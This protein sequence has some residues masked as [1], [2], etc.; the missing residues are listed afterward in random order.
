MVLMFCGCDI[1]S[2]TVSIVRLCV[3]AAMNIVMFLG[4]QVLS[5]ASAAWSLFHYN[6]GGQGVV[7]S[8]DFKFGSLAYSV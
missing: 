8:Q 5:A 3:E 2:I 6:V 1:Y 7:V 4:C